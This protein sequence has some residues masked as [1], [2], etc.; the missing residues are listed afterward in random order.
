MANTHVGF[1]I[2]DGGF[3]EKMRGLKRTAQD[4]VR[5]IIDDNKEAAKSGDDLLKSIEAQIKA[6]ERAGQT[7]QRRE[8]GRLGIRRDEQL[9]ANRDPSVRNQIERDY[10]VS[11]SGVSSSGRE[12]TEQISAMREMV[13][14]LKKQTDLMANQESIAQAQRADVMSMSPEDSARTMMLQD[15]GRK[16]GAAKGGGMMSGLKGFGAAALGIGGAMWLANNLMGSYTAAAAAETGELYDVEMTKMWL[17]PLG[18]I[19]TAG[20]ERHISS[21]EG[22]E[23]ARAAAYG[24]TGKQ[25]GTI[26]T[27]IDPT[28]GKPRRYVYGERKGELRD[29][30]ILSTGLDWGTQYGFTTTELLPMLTDIEESLGFSYNNLENV[31]Q[32]SRAYNVER[33]QMAKMVGL[34][35]YDESNFLASGAYISSQLS[36]DD[37]ADV[38]NVIE[39]L[40]QLT[41]SQLNTVGQVN[42]LEMAQTV[43]AL[44]GA[45]GAF[46]GDL[47]AGRIQKMQGTL[48]GTG[49]EYQQA[50]KYQMLR[51]I[52]PEANWWEIKEMQE[53]GIYTP[54]F[55]GKVF[56]RAEGYGKDINSMQFLS[57]MTGLGPQ[58]TRTMWEYYKA[59]PSFMDRFKGMSSEQI[60]A[61]WV[62][63]KEEAGMGKGTA[64]A[65]IKRTE[66]NEAFIVSA[67]K[68][69]DAVV[70]QSEHMKNIKETFDKLEGA[71]V[72]FIAWLVEV[73]SGDD[74]AFS[75]TVSKSVAKGILT[76]ILNAP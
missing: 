41:Q 46:G 16:P 34:G 51:E 5:G 8:R 67:T 13:D 58:D 61:E 6:M 66:I 2:D 43:M 73:M 49:N 14:I 63:I 15:M 56:E 71:S 7:D 39:A 76:A 33:G 47:M 68:G 57:E 28:T 64:A 32:F 69:I 27:P 3:D 52:N 22:W 9:A 74:P 42:T 70:E 35:R 4:T 26:G 55:M 38:T 18:N 11:M 23:R 75:D 24:A 44:R 25:Y 19:M 12:Q 17:G 62:K 60:E 53:M 59:N 40:T 1:S 72:G 50:L 36:G 37:R 21:R 45:G 30:E 10:K 65:D 20:E 31:V 54:G 48:T 29:P